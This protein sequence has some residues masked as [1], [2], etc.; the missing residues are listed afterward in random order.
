MNV[1]DMSA[2]QVEKEIAGFK[3]QIE[4]NRVRW[5]DSDVSESAL[6]ERAA[7]CGLAMAELRLQVIKDGGAE[8]PVLVKDGV[9]VATKTERGNWGDVWIVRTP[10]QKWEYVNVG[11]ESKKG[12]TV[13]RRIVP[14]KVTCTGTWIAM[15]TPE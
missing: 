10:G 6:S 1:N 2:V 8:F 5:A 13:E 9:V 7:N 14:A 12:Y 4:R 11:K 15:V 3:A